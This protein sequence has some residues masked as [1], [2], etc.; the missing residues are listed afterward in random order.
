MGSRKIKDLQVSTFLF[1]VMCDRALESEPFVTREE[2]EA[3]AQAQGN[4]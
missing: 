3:R 4:P 2:A 1:L